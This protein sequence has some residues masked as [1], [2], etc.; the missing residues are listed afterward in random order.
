MALLVDLELAWIPV[1][2]SVHGRLELPQSAVF[3]PIVPAR[4]KPLPALVDELNLTKSHNL[5]KVYSG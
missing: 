4:V 3:Q 5:T 1:R 2:V